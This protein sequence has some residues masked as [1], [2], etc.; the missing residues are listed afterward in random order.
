MAP[1]PFAPAGL[2]VGLAGFLLEYFLV[3][4]LASRVV[5]FR[6]R[7]ARIV[8]LRVCCHPPLR[9]DPIQARVP[10]HEEHERGHM[11]DPCADNEHNAPAIQAGVRSQGRW[12][13]PFAAILALSCLYFVLIN[14]AR[15]FRLFRWLHY[16]Y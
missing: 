16:L 2:A 8:L 12:A 6:L 9:R 11:P 3:R 15:R 4:D 5:F 13:N 14:W 7:D 1:H 10:L